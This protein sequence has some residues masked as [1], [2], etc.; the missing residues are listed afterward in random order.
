MSEEER[1]HNGLT[2]RDVLRVLG[3]SAGLAC[4]APLTGCGVAWE[5]QHVIPV[6]SWHKGVCRFCGTGCGMMIGVKENKVVDVKGDEYAHNRG[7]LCIKGIVNKEILYT[8]GR[9]VYPMIRKNG[10]LGRASW[11]EAMALVAERFRE[12]IEQYGPDSVAYYGSGQLYTPRDL[13]S[14]QVI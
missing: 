12:A 14:Q 4:M 13:H 7:R 11:E 9:A 8:E 1:E 6:D 3:M 5:R 2:R 10:K